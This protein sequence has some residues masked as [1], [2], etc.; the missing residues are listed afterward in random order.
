MRTMVDSLAVG[1]FPTHS[2]TAG[3]LAPIGDPVTL[4]GLA[5][6]I[7]CVAFVSTTLQRIPNVGVLATA[8]WPVVR[9]NLIKKSSSFERR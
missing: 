7:V 3:S 6:L 2:L 5:A 8:D 1:V 4:L 9:S